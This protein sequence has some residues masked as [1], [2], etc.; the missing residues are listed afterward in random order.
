[1]RERTVALT[2]GRGQH[3]PSATGETQRSQVT[4]LH[5]VRTEHLRYTTAA[6]MLEPRGFGPELDGCTMPGNDWISVG[7]YSNFES[8]Q[9]VSGRLRIE[10]VDNQVV[11]AEPGGPLYGALGEWA[12]LVAP[13]RLEAAR[14]ILDELPIADAELTSLALKDP[15]PDDFDP[16]R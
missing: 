14:R 5:P 11:S 1:V 4:L 13:E 8:A 6:N 3:P 9:I 12:I 16:S 7:A 15:P 10:G 2:G